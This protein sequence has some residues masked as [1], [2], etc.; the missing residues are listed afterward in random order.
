[1]S[2]SCSEGEV[3][4]AVLLVA[5]AFPFGDF[6]R[7]VLAFANEAGQLVERKLL[8]GLRDL[9]SRE[10]PYAAHLFSS[11][12]GIN[13][14]SCRLNLIVLVTMEGGCSDDEFD[15]MA[16]RITA[17]LEDLAEEVFDTDTPVVFIVDPDG[18]ASFGFI[19]SEPFR[20]QR[21]GR[22]HDGFHLQ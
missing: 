3:D 2:L 9:A 15:A 6:D 1:M 19:L 16:L 11:S 8:P 12:I 4:I 22:T 17:D 20:A 21:T 14:G 13:V 7:R 5:E 18:E 10:G